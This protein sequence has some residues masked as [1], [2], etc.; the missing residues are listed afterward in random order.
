MTSS[1]G[2]VGP[3]SDVVTGVDRSLRGASVGVAPESGTVPGSAGRPGADS[4][5]LA[6]A[7]PA[8]GA[9]G[10]AGEAGADSD[11]DAGLRAASLAACMA[12]VALTLCDTGWSA[13]DTGRCST[14]RGA[15]SAMSVLLTVTGAAL[16]REAITWL[17]G[18]AA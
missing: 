17:I 13:A 12:T 18:I 3:G 5:A 2:S 15:A 7:V 9:T 16:P 14:T 6:G 10:A 8:G 4:G 11:R 1:A